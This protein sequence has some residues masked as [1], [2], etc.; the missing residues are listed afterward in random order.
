MSKTI[1][2]SLLSEQAS[3]VIIWGHLICYWILFFPSSFN[4][5]VLSI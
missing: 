1:P 2:V 5:T 3:I 4:Y